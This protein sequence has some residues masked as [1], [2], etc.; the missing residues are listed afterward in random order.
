M[1][2]YGSGFSQF[3]PTIQKLVQLRKLRVPRI[4]VGGYGSGFLDPD[5][6]VSD[7]MKNYFSKEKL[8]NSKIKIKIKLK[9]K[10]TGTLD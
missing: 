5:F 10:V 6:L 8:R 3:L 7:V 2:G 1:G 4:Y 9:L